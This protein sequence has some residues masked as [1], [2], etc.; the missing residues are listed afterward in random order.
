MKGVN[1]AAVPELSLVAAVA[2]NGVIGRGRAMPWHLPADLA[3]FKRVTLG[4]PI[5]MGRRTYE[6]IGRPLPGRRNIVVTRSP[7]FVGAG[8]ESAAGLTEA[9]AL[10]RDV[11]EI[12]VIG[13]GE[14]Y[15]AALPIACRIYLTRVHAAVAGDTH[16]P[17]FD[18]AEWEEVAREERAADEKNAF[19]L[20]FLV[21]ERR[22]A[23]TA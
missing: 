2:E 21:L 12:M 13:G 5:V 23:R 20:T 17:E 4:K 7:G 9:I 10:T 6:A 8:V 15:A 18:P 11:E 19:A 16:F 14:L 3:H 22:N 1:H